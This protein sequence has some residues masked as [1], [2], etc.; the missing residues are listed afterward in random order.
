MRIAGTIRKAWVILL[1]DT[2]STHNFLNIELAERLGL[3]PDKQTAFKVLVA[4]RER[5]SNKGKCSAVPVWLGG[6]LFTLE[7]FL[8]DL[9]GYDSVLGAQ[10]LKMLGP[11]L[12]DFS[13]LCMSFRWQGKKVTLVGLEAPRNRILEGPEMQKELRHNGE[14]VLLQLF[15]VQLGV[16]Q[17]CL[18]VDSPDLQLLL[19][20][21]QDIFAEP[22]GLPP[23][24]SHDHKIPL[25]QGSSPVNV[26]PY[27]FPYYQKNEIEKIVLDLLNSGVV[28]AN[29]SPYS[30][31]VLL[32]KKHD[33]SW[34]LYVDYRALN[35]TTI[36]DKYP[37]PVIDELLDELHG[38]QYFSKLDLRSGYHQIRMQ[39]Q[40][41][42]K[43]A[44]RIHHGHFEFLVMPFGLTNAPSTFQSLMNDIF[45]GYLRKFVLVF[46]DDILIYSKSWED[47]LYHLTCVFDILRTSHLFVRM[48][49][50]SFGQQRV[51][52]LGH[53]IEQNG[54]AVDLAKIQA[55]LAW[56]R[57]SNIK[58]L[59]GFLGLTGYYRKFIQ[60]YGTIARPLTQ[61]LKKDAFGWNEE[62]SDS[63]DRLKEAMTKA[64]VLALPDFSKTFVIECDA[65][66]CGIGAVLMQDRR[67]IAYF[68]QALHGRNLK[69]STYEKEM[70]ALVTSIQRWHPYLLG[71]RFVVRTD[72]RSLKYLW[73]QTIAT[74]AQQRWLIKLM[75]YDFTIEY[76][77]GHDNRAAD[78]LSRQL[79]GTLMALSVPIP[80][81][82]ESIKHEVQHDPDLQALATRIQ[83]NEAVGPW[84]LQAGLIYFKDRV[85]L[86]AESPTTAAIIAEFHNSTHE[87]YHKGLQRIRSV[88]YWPKMKQQLRTF[89]RNCDICQHL[90][91]EAT[92]PAGL[93]QPLPI[94]EHIWSVIS[95]DFI[96]GLPKSY[97]RTTIFVVVDRFSKYGHFT[98][99]KHP[100]TAPQVAQ[101]F[102]EVIFRLHGIPT[103]I[104]CDRDPVFTGIFWRELFRLHSTK[105]NFSSAYHPQTDGQ[106]EVV[107][108]TIEMYLRCFTSSSPRQWAKWLPWVEYCYN[109]GFHSATKR[110]PFEIVYGRPPPPL[111]PYIP[112]TTRSAAVEEALLSR[113]Q[114][115]LEVRQ[116]LLGAQNRMKQV[117][118]KSHVE[119]IFFGGGLGVLT[120][121]RVQAAISS[122]AG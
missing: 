20:K 11:I 116:Q 111:L 23:M 1:A 104:V 22:Q 3:E 42:E 4:N 31:P 80:Y 92:K 38:A 44:F 74:E 94:P 119:R 40:D 84:H 110:T 55:M 83:Q 95:M 41:V 75:G 63:F 53:F 49:K 21:F 113:D 39:E 34:R 114:V 106:T 112:G 35:R 79:E 72:H 97:G 65:S 90:K 86:K 58:A 51:N 78:A 8:I 7:F 5:L 117:Y 28:R 9:R 25:I 68:S 88:F 87:G 24:R 61:L 47:H 18:G 93:L 59:R 103:S 54:V 99:L 12:W 15:A 17:C 29:T 105:F 82:I 73:D 70:L 96:D 26:R 77:K 76:K 98:P 81:W 33:G 27:R 121:P 30:S 48:D 60:H 19:E 56:P 115:L 71:Q 14:G 10:W 45:R 69:L 57:P 67:P 32:V 36:K 100:Y 50:C 16:E 107:N 101:T 46:F 64:P 66:G 109:T 37:I 13:S 102:F 43:T 62:A 89:I 120:A 108:R 6:T 91:A 2:R 118:D 85:Y 122:Q 52:Y